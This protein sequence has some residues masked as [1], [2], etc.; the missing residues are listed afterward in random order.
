MGI[1]DA[2]VVRV[3]CRTQVSNYLCKDYQEGV[4]GPAAAEI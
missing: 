3:L 2:N 1:K 4:L